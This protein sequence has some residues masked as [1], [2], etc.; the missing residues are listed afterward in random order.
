MDVSVIIVNYN[1]K[2]LL[3]GCLASLQAHT[4][5]IYYEIIV[6]DNASK[7][8]AEPFIKEKF[9][10]VIFVRNSENV[11]FGR[12]N[13][14]GVDLAKGKY[15]FFLNSDT[16]LKNNS[17]KYM[18][19]FMENDG[20]LFTIGAVGAL[21]HNPFG[22]ITH[23]SGFFPTPACILKQA[24]YSYCGIRNKWER[25][26][27]FGESFFYVDYITGADLFMSRELFYNINGFDKNFFMY[28]EETDLQ[29]RMS[30]LGYSSAIIAGPEIIHLEGASFLKDNKI[31]V[32]NTRR[33]MFDRSK[34]Y[35]VKKHYNLVCYLI[36][37]VLYI[38]IR[39]A[40]LFDIKY[41]LKERLQYFYSLF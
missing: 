1:T 18:F 16:L 3:L 6:V 27:F 35:Y 4:R 19:D 41:T 13:N 9:K 2:D 34:T 25:K 31:Q 8:D 21:L 30:L 22:E 12:A 5:D 7:E 33:I 14:I 23:S 15:L 28:F 17:L 10:D 32:S 39:L 24:L 37:R 29:K 36:F 38:I 20:N 26:S 40:T 11:G